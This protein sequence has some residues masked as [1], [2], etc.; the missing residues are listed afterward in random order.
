V[1]DRISLHTLS[2]ESMRPAYPSIVVGADAG[3]LV[4]HPVDGSVFVLDTE[5]AATRMIVPG[6]RRRVRLL[7]VDTETY[8]GA[9]SKTL[10]HGRTGEYQASLPLPSRGRDL[11][12][13]LSARPH[14][15]SHTHLPH[16]GCVKNQP[17]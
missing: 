16:Q 8:V 12:D 15:L 11:L 7:D 6:P 14:V 10:W 9:D 1:H 13:Q 4:A 5:L 3:G 2:R 17:K